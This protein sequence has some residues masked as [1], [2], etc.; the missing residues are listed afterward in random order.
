MIWYLLSF[1][2]HLYR[3]VSIAFQWRAYDFKES[4][5]ED[6]SEKYGSFYPSKRTSNASIKFD[7]SKK[8]RLG[9]TMSLSGGVD[10][11]GQCI[12]VLTSG[13]DSQGMN[14]AIRATIRMGIYAGAEMYAVHWGYQGLV[15]GGDNIKK[16]CWED[17]SGILNKGGTVIGTARC[18]DFR[19]RKGRKK[20]ALNLVQRKISNLVVIGGDGSLTGAD[21][22]RK[23]WPSLIQELLAEGSITETDSE[24]CPYLSIVGM[25]GSIDNDFCGTDMTIGADTALHRILENVDAISTT[26]ES[27]QRA[28]ILEVMGRN[29]GYL[30][31]VAGISSGADWIFIPEWP[32]EDGWESEL[33]ENLKKMRSR[34]RLLTIIIIS[35][36]AQ[37]IHGNPITANKVKELLTN[38]LKLDTRVTILGHVQRGGRPSAFDRILAS[39]LGCEAALSIIE[40]NVAS[41]PMVM[42]LEG[43]Q[44][45]ARPLHQ[46]VEWCNEIKAAYNEKNFKKVVELRGSSFQTSLEM[47]TI[48]KHASFPTESKQGYTLGVI[49]VGA[50]AGGMN[51][52]VRS[53]V[54]T[55]LYHGHTVLGITNGFDGLLENSVHTMTWSEVDK[56]TE[57]GGCMLGVT[58]TLPDNDLEKIH[59]RLKEHHIDGLFIVG[60]FEAFVSLIQLTEARSS[61]SAFRIPMVLVPATMSNNVPGTWFSL[62][63][64]TTLN[65][66]VEC[67]DKIR[68]SAG[69]TARSVFIVETMG[70]KCGYLPTMAAIAAG[71]DSAYIFEECLTLE[72]LKRNIDHLKNKFTN[73]GLRRGLV[74]RSEHCNSNY[75]T[76]FITRLYS[77][78]GKKLFVVRSNVLGHIQQGGSPSTFDR[79]YGTRYGVKALHFLL[80]KI[81]EA[82]DEYGLVNATSSDSSCVL[83]HIKNHSQFTPVLDL[84]DKADFKNRLPKHYWWKRTRPLL[85]VLAQYKVMFAREVESHADEISIKNYIDEVEVEAFVD[86]MKMP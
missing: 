75:T 15:D 86:D 50:P 9:R 42:C 8:M 53:F 31:L 1:A 25:V 51:A 40:A 18:Q 81:E 59:R 14:A 33:C 5:N 68:Q 65:V 19:D 72:E 54:R 60:G 57:I 34:G 23:E 11:T 73:S 44:I 58:R 49:N 28:F 38:S 69:S 84:K 77:E 64:D 13:G 76:D 32:P 45:I 27:H 20:A 24:M 79:L 61:Y 41:E 6:L 3:T 39:R 22:F 67:C 82:K 85:K 12:A 7:G 55:A 17:V 71:A 35:E 43:S 10:G 16:V 30:A 4:E 26:A 66:I 63:A 47:Y 83:G 62:G 21:I 80:Q 29:C 36:G 74:L 37:D 52:A 48:L 56:W 78:E 2:S 70:G 46:C